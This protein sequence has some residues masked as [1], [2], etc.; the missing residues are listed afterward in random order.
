MEGEGDHEALVPK[1]DRSF[2][3][4]G[5]I[6][7]YTLA[8]NFLAIFVSSIVVIGTLASLQSDL[9]GNDFYHNTSAPNVSSHVCILYAECNNDPN[10]ESGPCIIAPNG[11]RAC[12]GT[13]TLFG[14]MM[15]LSLAFIVSLIIKAFLRH[16]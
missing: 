1:R 15:A 11:N 9:C 7:N 14:L 6:V 2:C 12:E 5:A 4:L 10:N 13:M 16:E 8:L 3:S